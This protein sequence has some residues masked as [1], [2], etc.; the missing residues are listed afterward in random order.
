MIQASKPASALLSGST[1][2]RWQ[3]A[4][5]RLRHSVPSGSLAGAPRLEGADPSKLADRELRDTIRS[6]YRAVV[7]VRGGAAVR[8]KG[9]RG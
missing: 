9:A 7:P 8:A 1:L 5:G 4:S 3:Q 2:R 6:F